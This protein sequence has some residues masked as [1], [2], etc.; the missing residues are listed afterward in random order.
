MKNV[1]VLVL[2]IVLFGLQPSYSQTTGIQK[3]NIYIG[4][5]GGMNMAKMNLPNQSSDDQNISSL[6]VYGGGLTLD[7]RISENIFARIEPMYLQKGTTIEEGTDAVNQ[8]GG[9][10]KLS[11]IEIPILIQYNFVNS[12]NPYLVAGPYLGYNLKS[13]IEFETMELKFTGDM[14]EVTETFDFGLTF[15]GGMQIPMSFGICFFEGRYSFGLINQMKGGTTTL[16]SNL[17]EFDLTSD[18]EED[19]YTNRGFQLYA[20]IFI[21]IG[22]N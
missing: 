14:K 19:K 20:G 6:L 1:T 11:S 5:L 22:N 15:G 7:V 10:I 4:I 8:P 9:K 3:D 17:L 18:K 13:E 12:L 16:S 2:T 21:P